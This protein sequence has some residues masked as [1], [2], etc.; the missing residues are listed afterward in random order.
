MK[1]KLNYIILY[2]ADLERSLTFYRD[3]LGLPVRG[4][5]GTYIE[6]DTG[7][8]VLAMLPLQEAKEMTGLNVPQE[9]RTSN[10]FELGFVVENVQEMIEG[11]RQK[12]VP[13]LVEPKTKPWGQVV[14]Y[15]ADPDGHYIEICTAM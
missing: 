5:H 11:L 3:K 7:S 8:T 10:T 9:A 14:A 6:F 13:V 15:V 12:G 4:I 2:V 1:A